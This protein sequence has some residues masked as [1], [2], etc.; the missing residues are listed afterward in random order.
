MGY[1]TGYGL[2]MDIGDVV[3]KVWIGWYA[4]QIALHGKL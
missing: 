2:F 1:D 4:P 3:V